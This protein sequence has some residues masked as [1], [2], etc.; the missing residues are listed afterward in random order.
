MDAMRPIIWKW[1][2]IAASVLGVLLIASETEVGTFIQERKAD[3]VMSEAFQTDSIEALEHN[4]LMQRIMAEAKQHEVAPINARIDRVWKAIPGYN[5]V[6]ADIE[7]TY[8]ANKGKSEQD[9]LKWILREVKP[10]VSLRDLEPQP[11]YRGNPN[12]PMVALM[13]NVAWGNEFITPMLK[14]LQ[15][16]KVK[17]SFFLDGSWLSKNPDVAKQIQ[18]EGHELENHAYTH[19]NMSELSAGLQ[20]QQIEKTK[21]LLKET[22][23]VENKWFAPPSGDFNALTV[24]TAHAH[25]L[26][27][28]LWTL[29]TVDWKKPEPS[30][31]LQ[32]IRKKVEPG[33]LILM[34]PTSSSSRA[35]QDMI[36]I[37]KD[38]GFHPGT[39]SDTLSEQ[40]VP[41]VP[42]ERR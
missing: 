35:L 6:E 13:I 3:L 16:E 1:I 30:T 20:S 14:V 21:R 25:G 31:I 29:D 7:R 5:G 34:H 28:V 39:V 11:I 24:T 32:K 8:K 12:K 38:K 33:T 19:P 27:T 9:K 40:R 4:P 22:L 41:L 37:I 10:E 2:V 23:G 26:S 18:A 17:A 36:R 42:V 15:E